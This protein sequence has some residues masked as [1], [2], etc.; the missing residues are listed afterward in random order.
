MSHD[1][2]SLAA[3]RP[4][5]EYTV[6]LRQGWDGELAIFVEDLQNDPRSRKAVADALRRAADLLDDTK[7]TP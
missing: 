4:A 5:V 2:V 3:K 1:V 6:R 7:D